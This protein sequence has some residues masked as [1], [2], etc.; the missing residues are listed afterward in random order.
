[1]RCEKCSKKVVV[2]SK[3]QSGRFCSRACA[4]S[5][6]WSEADK[7]KKSLSAHASD[8]IKL[9]GI[10]NSKIMLRKYRDERILRGEPEDNKVEVHCLSCG[11]I[12]YR[13]RWRK[14][15]Y[16]S[17]ICANAANKIRCST[18][19]ERKRLRDIGRMGGFGKKGYTKDGTRYQSKLE[20]SCFEFLEE[21]NIKFVPH[22][23][24]PNSSKVSDCYLPEKDLWVEIDGIDREKR[25]KWLGKD[26]EYWCNKL[27]LYNTLKLK[28][29]V[30]KTLEEF[31]RWV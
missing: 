24:L 2:T 9:M 4:N 15:K 30:V 6:T 27:T 5:R 17:V 10:E 14:H 25:K 19:E 1:M 31:A 16:C 8:K 3:Y 13:S 29:V 22:K 20:K 18:L 28:Y 11:K 26:Y 21:N 7:L 23:Y 12:V